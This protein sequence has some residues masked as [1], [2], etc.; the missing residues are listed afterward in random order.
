MATCAGSAAVATVYFG[1]GSVKTTKFRLNKQGNGSQTLPFD[2]TVTAVEV[3]LVNASK[4]YLCWS[5]GA[6]SCQGK[7][8]HDNLAGRVRG[9]LVP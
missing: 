4:K 9:V 3:T 6:F 8:K 5:N 2:S 7:P 1:D